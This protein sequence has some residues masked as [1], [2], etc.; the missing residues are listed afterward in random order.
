M[1]KTYST[2]NVTR[3]VIEPRIIPRSEHNISRSNIN[4]NAL[5]VLYRLKN[6]GYKAYLVGG[7]V[8]DLLLGLKPKDFDVVTDARPEQIREL[9]RNCR[10]IGR[11]F[12]LAHIR[13]GREII[14]VSTFRAPHQTVAGEGHTEDGRIVR[15]NVYGDIDDDVWRRDFTVNALFY[16]IEDFS[17]VD[18]VGGLSDIKAKQLRLI[19]DP[20]ERY[21][22]DPV[23]M[24]RAVRF[25]VKLGF[26]L[27]PATEQPITE[28]DHLLQDI[29][30]ARLFEEFMKLFMNG[31]A[32]AAYNQ[33][34]RYGLF[35]H[36]F[37]ETD[38][39]LDKDNSGF[40][41]GLL[42]NAFKN[43]DIRLTEDKP[44]TPGFLIATLLWI[45][46]IRLAEGYKSNGLSEMDAIS[47]AS[48]SVISR[49][50]KS[51]SMPR[52]FTQMAREIW[53]LQTR[54]KHHHGNRP[55]RL[56]SHPRFR[57][58]YDFLLL[59]KEVGDNVLDLADWWTEFLVK[60]KI[61]D[62]DSIATD[63]KAPRR[64][65]QRKRNIT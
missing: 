41:H 61:Q 9:F 48:D 54:L 52:R 4:E 1:V 31:C 55:Y 59:R 29:P 16:N 38:Q 13:F 58:A 65:H 19:G 8:R 12:R 33:L 22:E 14:E 50:V 64:R 32:L 40:M 23:R 26:T 63:R 20:V 56:V 39:A 42:S 62:T 35:V 53:N 6:A 45:P 18:Y 44:V 46:M 10:L 37:P 17:L 57:A 34:R 11:R 15:D 43:T 60:N 5:K 7:S 2:D 30:P 27:H 3:L 25:A 28:L 47:L 49:Q 24:L 21:R 51:I 36:L